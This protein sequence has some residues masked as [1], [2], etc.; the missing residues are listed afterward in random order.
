[1]PGA[2]KAVKEDFATRL[3]AVSPIV[4]TEDGYYFGSGCAAH[5][6]GE[7]E[8][9]WVINKTTG[10]GAAIIMRSIPA[11]PG[12]TA[13]HENFELYGTIPT[14]LMDWAVEHRMTEGNVR[15]VQ[16]PITMVLSPSR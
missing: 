13:A 3:S 4:E 9:A 1:M 10:K 2:L 7:N 6:C 16:E 14:P 8:A 11:I 12:G 5:E 15:E